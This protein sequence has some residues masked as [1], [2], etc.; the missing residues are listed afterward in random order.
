MKI[1][2][3]IIGPENLVTAIKKVADEFEELESVLLVYESEKESPALIKQCKE[4]IDVYL[5]SGK[6]P[7]YLSQNDLPPDSRSIYIPFEGTDIYSVIFHI[8]R[9]YHFYPSV[10]FDVIT[11]DVLQETFEELQIADF[12]WSVTT[13][14]DEYDGEKLS[15]HHLQLWKEGKFQVVATCLNS[16]Y[17]KLRELKIPVFLVKHTNQTIRETIKKAILLGKEHKKHSAQITILQFKIDES[18]YIEQNDHLHV[19]KTI[20]DLSNLFF[21]RMGELDEDIVTLYTTRGIIER[22]TDHFMDFSLFE[23]IFE[24]YPFFI[25]FGIGMGD[26]GEG[27]AYNANK[28]LTMAMQDGGNCGFLIDDQKRAYGPFGSGTTM[29]YSL[30]DGEGYSIPHS[31]RKL[32]SWLTTLRKEVVTT[33]EISNALSTSERNAA[34]LIKSLKNKEIAEVIGKEKMA[35]KGRPRPIYKVDLHKLAEELGEEVELT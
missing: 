2:M 20:N 4:I 11:P 23:Q 9:T 7:Y 33:R 27:A 25:N 19:K 5:F 31:M 8:Y 13:M 12:Q 1:K 6:F 18:A 16:V 24:R 28:A 15:E 34:R 26:T 22:L 32:Y 14:D 30:V 29:E 17:V 3:A 35:Q 21:T 10:S